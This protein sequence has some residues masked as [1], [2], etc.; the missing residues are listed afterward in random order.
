MKS[1]LL[2]QKKLLDLNKDKNAYLTSSIYEELENHT[3]KNKPKDLFRK[4][5]P[6]PRNFKSRHLSIEDNTGRIFTEKIEI[7]DRWRQYCETLV[8][9]N[10]YKKIKA[11]REEI[12]HNEHKEI[13]HSYVS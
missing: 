9:G 12:E 13:E 5:S 10:E 6:P 8:P 1:S 2:Q 11:P 3:N 7:L 4:F